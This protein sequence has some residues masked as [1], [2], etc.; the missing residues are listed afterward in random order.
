MINWRETVESY[1]TRVT[2][3]YRSNCLKDG[4]IASPD[5]LQQLA[6]SIAE[7]H[8]PAKVRQTDRHRSTL[9]QG[10]SVIRFVGFKSLKRLN[11]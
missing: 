6:T 1:L 7:D 5:F 8:A 10:C 11:K 4:S 9:L 2:Q 3:R